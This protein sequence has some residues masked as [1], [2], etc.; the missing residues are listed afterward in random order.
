V[1]L[2][3]QYSKAFTLIELIIVV[4][5][6]AVL[7][8]L[9]AVDFTKAQAKSRD[10]KR[11]SDLSIIRAA[12][13]VYRND[14]GSFK[15]D[16]NANGTILHTGCAGGGEGFFNKEN[17]SGANPV[18]NSIIDT[19]NPDYGYPHSIASGLVSFGYLSAAPK[20]PLADKGHADYMY[21]F[22]P[23]IA[24]DDAA[25]Y[26]ALENPTSAEAATCAADSDCNSM[27]NSYQGSDGVKINYKIMK[28]NM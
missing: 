12:A 19:S 13:Q 20:D 2:R 6:I 3:K 8:T 14:R 27:G 1:L 15:I 25:V 26:A 24:T 17:G 10:A 4:S 9:V 28:S 16:Y 23:Y 7:A 5:I 22:G 18:C 21:Y 11:R